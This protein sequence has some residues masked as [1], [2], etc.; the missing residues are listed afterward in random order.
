MGRQ[1]GGDRG[2]IEVGLLR[3][4]RMH[5][6]W[7]IRACLDELNR[8]CDEWMFQVLDEATRRTGRLVKVTR[9]L[10]LKGFKLKQLNLKLVRWD[11]A[12]KART[13][14][15]YPQQLGQ[16]L[17]IDPPKS[18]LW[19]WEHLVKPLMP[20]RVA[21][22]TQLIDSSSPA[23]RATIEQHSRL[24]TLPAFLGGC[25]KMPWPPNPDTWMPPVGPLTFGPDGTFV[26][27]E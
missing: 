2:L 5:E 10:S 7:P 16:M 8:Y 14:D 9:T 12:T 20:R 27:Y 22:R 23:G 17:F 18:L 13:Q 26:R 6:L 15:L 11:A 21:E 24:E 19:A 3:E 4:L 1:G 25:S